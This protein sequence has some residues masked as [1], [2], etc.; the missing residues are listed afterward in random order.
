MKKALIISGITIIV[1]FT[2][3][4]L[5]ISP[6]AE[7]FIE[8][9]SKDLVGR[10]ISMENLSVNIFSGSLKID[11]FTLYESDETTSFVSFK[12]LD[13]NVNILGLLANKLEIE[14]ILLSEA[15]VRVIQDG[16]YFNFNDIIDFFSSDSTETETVE[17]ENPLAIIINDIHLE[18]SYL[19][20]Q[21]KEVGS[22][23]NLKDISIIIPG[24]D[25]SDLQADMGLK[26][27]FTNG[28][29]LATKIKYDTDKALYD[30][31]LHIKNFHL[32][33]ILP[34]LQQSLLVDNL[35]G[36]FS[37]NLSIKG[38]TEHIMELDVNGNILISDFNVFDAQ[39]QAIATFDSIYTEIKH[40]DLNKNLVELN[41]L[42]INGL[43][44]HF[45]FFKDGSD[46]FTKLFKEEENQSI[47]SS[48]ATAESKDDTYFL[49]IKDLKIVNANF[50]YID[51]TLPQQF[52]YDISNI[53]LDATNFSLDKTNNVNITALLQKTGKLKIKW[54][55]SIE[56]ISNQNI[57]VTLNNLDLKPFTPYS[58]SMFGNPITDGHISIQSQ[59]II[60]NNN[61]IGTNKINM[62]NP[63]IGEK[64]KSVQSEYNIPLK[65]GIYILTDKNGKV[66]LDLPISGNIDSPDFSYGKIIL[67]TL[68]NLLVKVAAS[69]FNALKNGSEN[70]E[71]IY[72][73]ATATEFTDEEYSQFAK[74]GNILREKPELKLQLTQN[75]LYTNAITEYCL[76]ELK[77]NMAIQD[78]SNSINEYN[79]NDLLVK[80]KYLSIPTKSPELTAFA[81]KLMSEKGLSI[82]NKQTNEEK[83]VL[84]YSNEMKSIIEKDM[85]WRNSLIQNYLTNQ[86]SI[87]DSS[88]I[89]SSY[90]IETD[91]VKKFKDNYK[92]E[93]RFE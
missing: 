69:P 54:I 52:N 2:A 41:S 87:A 57:T 39:N 33:P 38:S 71:E 42:H 60:T 5:A 28:G 36:I 3:I 30:L 45:E 61:L 18:H 32:S 46:N 56:D 92:V 14:H 4:A 40:V 86:C 79:A 10:K 89:M 31:E 75:L 51:N 72:F 23:W 88:L 43:S 53:C 77:K 12:F 83:A 67:K 55:G 35:E 26:L 65:M 19:S 59:N 50:N 24:I 25:L 29:Q 8:K 68:G 20:Y 22:E 62:Y 73:S 7:Y 16:D 6:I 70:I 66:D 84:I 80:E 58:L 82:N 48:Q 13:V 34:Y 63:K 44:S 93:W 27:D 15:N 85:N 9:N 91:T 64:D 17:D 81:N 47:D 74:L 11:D 37:S 1:L 90:L 78:S 21:D 49:N 76:T